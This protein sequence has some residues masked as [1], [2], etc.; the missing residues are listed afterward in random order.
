MGPARF[1][2]AAPAIELVYSI[3]KDL[4]SHHLTN[5]FVRF[6]HSSKCFSGQNMVSGTSIEAHVAAHTRISSPRWKTRTPGGESLM[7]ST[8][9]ETLKLCIWLWFFSWWK[10]V[11]QHARTK[12]HASCAS[13]TSVRSRWSTFTSSHQSMT[14]TES[15]WL[16]LLKSSVSNAWMLS[17]IWPVNHCVGS[18]VLV[19]GWDLQGWVM[20]LRNTTL[21]NT[22]FPSVTN[23]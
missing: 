7:A 12:V 14:E 11:F 17:A 16:F 15:Q 1:A 18:T 23:C 8:Y 2:L 4:A 6:Y 3:L 13:S 19:F 21:R 10:T 20:V 9:H 22:W 5:S